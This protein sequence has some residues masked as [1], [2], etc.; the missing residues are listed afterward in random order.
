MFRAK[1]TEMLDDVPAWSDGNWPAQ[2]VIE[3]SSLEEAEHL[4]P[5]SFDSVVFSPPYANRFDYFESQKVELWFGG[6]VDTYGE[7]T[8]LRKRSLRSHLGAALGRPTVSRPEIDALI[9]R[10]DPG[11]LRRPDAGAGPHP[12]L[13]QRHGR[14]AAAPA[15]ASSSR[16]VGASSSSATPPTAA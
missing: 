10:I 2:R 13:L 1:L 9:E 14:G 5:G 7:M 8:A 11:V 15:G 12:G 6:F 3:G 4:E 16:A